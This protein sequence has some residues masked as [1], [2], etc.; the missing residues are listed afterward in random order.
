MILRAVLGLGG[1]FVIDFVEN[2][3][4]SIFKC[5]VFDLN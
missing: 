4:F 1:D 3:S 2:Y 5:V